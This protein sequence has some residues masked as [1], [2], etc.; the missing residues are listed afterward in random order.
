[1]SAPEPTPE[2]QG[3]SSDSWDSARERGAPEPQP[4]AVG[5]GRRRHRGALRS[6]GMRL[7][8]ARGPA[9]EG[10]SGRHPSGLQVP[11][12]GGPSFHSPPGLH[13]G[14]P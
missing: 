5:G 7:Q 3:R 1:M 14:P 10:L 6:W 8:R 11:V 4:G 9:A 2:P 12:P 13:Q